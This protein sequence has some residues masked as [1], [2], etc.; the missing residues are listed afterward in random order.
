MTYTERAEE[1]VTVSGNC[2][3]A[4]LARKRRSALS[5]CARDCARL[6]R[7]R[8][9]AGSDEEHHRKQRGYSKLL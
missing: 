8:E 5:D 2:Y 6:A 7:L 4:S 1:G 9:R 3:V